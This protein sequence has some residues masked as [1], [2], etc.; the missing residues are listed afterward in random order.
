MSDPAY[1]MVE[2]RLRFPAESPNAGKITPWIGLGGCLRIKDECEARRKFA[3]A[4]RDFGLVEA[5]LLK[6][7]VVNVHA[8]KRKRKGGDHV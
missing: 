2:G 4:I 7:F 6:V 5:R 3:C 8:A 1:W